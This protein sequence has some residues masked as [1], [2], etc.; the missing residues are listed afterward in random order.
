M[1]RGKRFESA[2]RLS[3]LFALALRRRGRKASN[4]TFGEGSELEHD[5][6]TSMRNYIRPEVRFHALLTQDEIQKLDVVR[7]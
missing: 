1:S 7:A 2:R 3:V 6:L 5:E 4:Y